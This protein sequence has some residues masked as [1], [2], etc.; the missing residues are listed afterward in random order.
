MAPAG[1]AAAAFAALSAA[2]ANSATRASL[3]KQFDGAVLFSLGEAG[4]YV[5]DLRVA[6][7]EGAG[8]VNGDHSDAPPPDLT[9][10]LSE[11]T[12]LQLVSG[13]LEPMSALMAGQLKVS[14]NMALAT[15]LQP[16]L[17]A[18]GQKPRAKL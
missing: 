15:K 18:A 10:K 14:G 1:G 5:L 9:L 4:K 12:F 6:A 3:V 11:E 8:V 13:E 17:A 16:V 7:G 2:L